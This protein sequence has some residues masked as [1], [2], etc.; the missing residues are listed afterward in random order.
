MNTPRTDFVAHAAA[1]PAQEPMHPEIKKMYE[2]YFDKCF[3][4]LSASASQTLDSVKIEEKN[5]G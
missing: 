5:S 4:E 3:R 1:Q 2:D